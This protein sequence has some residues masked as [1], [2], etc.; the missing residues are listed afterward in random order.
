MTDC[1][2]QIVAVIHT[3]CLPNPLLR[4]CIPKKFRWVG[5]SVGGSV[6]QSVSPSGITVAGVSGL[7]TG[8][9]NVFATNKLPSL[10]SRKSEMC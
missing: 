4:V 3:E 6:G 1:T 10:A 9:Q 8:P 2:W 7:Y 5:G